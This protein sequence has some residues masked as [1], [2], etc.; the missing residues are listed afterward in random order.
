MFDR[1]LRNE[2]FK[3][4]R[5]RGSGLVSVNEWLSYFNV[6]L[7]H[8][9]ILAGQDVTLQLEPVHH[10]ATD[11]FRSLGRER[12]NCKFREVRILTAVKE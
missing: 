8:V 1:S 5:R 6:R 9:E 7:H 2:V 4:P 11:N 3:T 10:V 12:R